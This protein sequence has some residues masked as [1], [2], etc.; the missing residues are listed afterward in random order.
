VLRD[1]RPVYVGSVVKPELPF[2]GL[3]SASTSNGR[4]IGVLS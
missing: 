4:F 2:S 3:M 1:V